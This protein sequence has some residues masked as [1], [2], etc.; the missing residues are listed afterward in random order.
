MID[1]NEIRVGNRFIRELRN[2]RGLEYDHDFI[3]TEEQMGKL[4]SDNIGLALQDLSPI[5]LSPKILDQC[6]FNHEIH[7]DSSYY[8]QDGLWFC[9]I[10]DNWYLATHTEYKPFQSLHQLQNLIHSLTGKELIYSPNTV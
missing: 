1:S 5:P 8:I 10:G 2:E 3:L 7:D 4:F 6:G 9:H